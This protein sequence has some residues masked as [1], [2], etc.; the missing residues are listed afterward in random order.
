MQKPNILL[1]TI[2]A[3]RY[4]IL[5]EMLDNGE[6]GNFQ[7]YIGLF[8]GPL[9]IYA[10]G[11]TTY[12][13]MPGIFASKIPALTTSG[14]QL[15]ERSFVQHL[16]DEGYYTVGINQGNPW[17]SSLYRFNAGFREFYEFLDVP[18]SDTLVHEHMK[19]HTG[20]SLIRHGER[21]NLMIKFLPKPLYAGLKRLRRHFRASRRADPALYDRLFKLRDRFERQL[22]TSVSS[23]SSHHAPFFLWIHF[24]DVH[25]PYI[26]SMDG[27]NDR[28]VIKTNVDFVRGAKNIEE[29]RKLYRH[30]IHYVFDQLIARILGEFERQNILKNACV[31]ITSDHGEEF[32]EHQEGGHKPHQCYRETHEVPC[33]L[34]FPGTPGLSAEKGRMIEEKSDLFQLIDIA[35]TLLDISGMRYDQLRYMGNSWLG[36]EITRR[37]LLTASGSPPQVSADPKESSGNDE[38][39]FVVLAKDWKLRAYRNEIRL[40]RRSDERLNHGAKQPEIVSQLLKVIE[41]VTA[42]AKRQDI[43]NRLLHSCGL[44]GRSLQ[45]ISK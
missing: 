33:F 44:V 30:A 36:N 14:I 19:P 22:W 32:Y 1:L 21:H 26:T 2:D 8:T 25:S 18:K 45:A 35:P 28:S 15:Y 16:E 40:F 6:L 41:Q 11:V 23:I 43:Y 5:Q 24:M 39:C 9:K 29:V 7:R 31:M 17:C 37:H 42:Q 13:S 4:D 27:I 3:L 20:K 10:N 38:K 12:D 34:K